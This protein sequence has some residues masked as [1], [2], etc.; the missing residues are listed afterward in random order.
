MK[1]AP[2]QLDLVADMATR[3]CINIKPVEVW[4]E[5]PLWTRED[6]VYRELGTRLCSIDAIHRILTI[7]DPRCCPCLVGI[8]L[9]QIGLLSTAKPAVGLFPLLGRG[10]SEVE[11]VGHGCRSCDQ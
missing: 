6:G 1:R 11:S 2:E 9:I 10:T 3:S 8:V 5:S 7:R 4:A